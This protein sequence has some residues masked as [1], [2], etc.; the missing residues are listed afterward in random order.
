MDH[1]C[2]SD[3]PPFGN[4]YRR[5]EQRSYA[6]PNSNLRVSDSE[7]HEM[8]DIL[9]RHYADGRLDKNEFDE[10]VGQAMAAKTHADLSGLLSDLPRVEPVS[11][12]MTPMPPRRR[13]RGLLEL[14]LIAAIVLAI[15]GVLA[16]PWHLG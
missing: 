16:A 13:H 5:Y 14:C 11:G 4:W 2:G 8:A 12:P 9:G 1:Y 6:A 7:R 10:R 3:A 15:G